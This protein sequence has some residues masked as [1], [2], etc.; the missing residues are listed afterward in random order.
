MVEQ[1]GI[2]AFCGNPTTTMPVHFIKETRDVESTHWRNLART[3]K[4]S[5]VSS[6]G[7]DMYRA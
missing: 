4:I 1:A 3:E 2:A 7:N 6:L 5:G